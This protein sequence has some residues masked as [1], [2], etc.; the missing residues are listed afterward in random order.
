M[1]SIFSLDST[2]D[3]L[4]NRT[5][6][7]PPSRPNP[8]RDYAKSATLSSH[9]RYYSHT[10]DEIIPPPEPSVS[11]PYATPYHSTEAFS[12]KRD[13]ITTH[14]M[15]QVTNDTLYASHNGS[16]PPYPVA[17]QPPT[18]QQ[19][20]TTYCM[21]PDSSPYLPIVYPPVP[22]ITSS[23]MLPTYNPTA[24]SPYMIHPASYYTA[25]Y[26]PFSPALFSPSIQNI[27]NE[28]YY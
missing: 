27:N 2:Q 13:H 6:S 15:H 17:M 25:Q 11:N 26:Y 3:A 18:Q 28:D 23:N 24:P 5:M 9:S 10:T 20:Q 14:G 22:S 8:R 21:N 4:S 16:I 12:T 19:Q 1:L 7:V